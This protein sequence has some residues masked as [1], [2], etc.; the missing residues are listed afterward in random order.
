[1]NELASSVVPSL[2]LS[3]RRWK[4][5]DVQSVFFSHV[6]ATPGSSSDVALLIDTR[7]VNSSLVTSW[8]SDSWELKGSMAVGSTMPS[9]K[10]PPV[11]APVLVLF[12][13]V[14]FFLLLH[15]PAT[16]ARDTSTT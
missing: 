15:A 10:T 6:V 7:P 12:V 3:S 14:V 8:P 16:K 11:F 13:V 4:V 5:H 1:M 9:R 2:N